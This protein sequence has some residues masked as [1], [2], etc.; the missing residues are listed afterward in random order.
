MPVVM[1]LDE[2]MDP[3]LVDYFLITTKKGNFIG[4]LTVILKKTH[5]KITKISLSDTSSVLYCIK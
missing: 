5:R 4:V 2:R 1:V 3:N